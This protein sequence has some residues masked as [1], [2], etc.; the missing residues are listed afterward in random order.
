MTKQKCLYPLWGFAEFTWWEDHS[1]TQ[2]KVK[3]SHSAFWKVA[4]F[5]KRHTPLFCQAHHHL[6]VLLL[7]TQLRLFIRS[8]ERINT[9]YK[10]RILCD[11]QRPSLV[12]EINKGQCSICFV[13]IVL[14]RCKATPSSLRHQLPGL[15]LGISPIRLSERHTT[16]QPA[17]TGRYP[18]WAHALIVGVGHDYKRYWCGSDKDWV[19][20]I[21]QPVVFISF[22]H[23]FQCVGWRIKLI[24]G[25]TTWN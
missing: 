3:L 22:L 24:I 19:K 7:G 4:H 13:H 11:P 16:T 23:V 25:R 12:Q 2:T 5:K 8:R 21:R 6:Q 20:F 17:S 9:G 14:V 1:N 18:P 15:E 10:L